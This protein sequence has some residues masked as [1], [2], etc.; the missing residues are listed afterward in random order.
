MERQSKG[1]TMA[2]K[3]R[4][5]G[6]TLLI[7][8]AIFIIVT[9]LFPIAWNFVLSFGSWSPLT[10]LKMVGFDNYTKLFQDTTTINAF[11]YSIFIALVSSII[12]I[13]LGMILALLIYRLGSREGSVFRLIFF[14]PAMMPFVIIGLLFVF[15]LSPQ[16]GLVN[17][18]LKLIGLGS[19]ARA[20][21]AEP[22]LVL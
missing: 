21:I 17:Q 13:I 11:K 2:S 7:P 15:L 14:T 8:A 20:W 6:I 5:L 19:L 10:N 3:N 18:F 12:A 1:R 9:M 22:G 16:I 4:I